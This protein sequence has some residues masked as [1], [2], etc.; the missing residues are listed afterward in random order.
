MDTPVCI[1]R[2]KW[3][4]IPKNPLLAA[5]LLL[6]QCANGQLVIEDFEAGNLSN[7]T[8]VDL[9]NDSN[10]VSIVNSTDANTS[11]VV[12]V[13]AETNSGN[14]PGAWLQANTNTIDATQNN[15][16]VTFDFQMVGGSNFDDAMFLIGDLDN[17]DYI[18]YT[19]NEH[20]GSNNLHSYINTTKS[21]I[22]TDI[23]AGLTDDTWYSATLTWNYQSNT[24]NYTINNFNSGSTIGS[25]STSH[26]LNNVQFAWGSLND[27]AR[28]D[29]ITITVTKPLVGTDFSDAST[30]LAT[31]GAY[32]NTQLD[33]LDTSDGITVSN[34]INFND[35]QWEGRS[36]IFPGFSDP[37]VII[38]R[39]DGNQNNTL[40]SIGDTISTSTQNGVYFEITIDSTTSIDLT[41]IEFE[42]RQATTNNTRTLTFGT[43]LTDTII[44]KEVGL[45][46]NEVDKQ[47]IEFTGPTYTGLTNTTVGFYFFAGEGSGTRDL[48]FDNIIL[49]GSVALTANNDNVTTNIQGAIKANVLANDTGYDTTTLQIINSPNNGTA[50][51]QDGSIIYKHTG[52]TAGTDT[53]RYSIDNAGSSTTQ[54]AELTI[55]ITNDFRL[56]PTTLNIPI[57]PPASSPDEL[58]YVDALP[59]LSFPGCVAIVQIPGQPKA[60]FIAS[61]NGSVWYV[62]DTTATT[63][64]SH[65]VLD[66]TK[67]TNFTNGRS[68]YSMTCYPDFAT[69]GNIIINYQ[70]DASRLPTPGTGETVHD[71]MPGLDQN[72]S[73]DDTI[74]CDLRVSRFTLSASHLA[75]VVANGMSDAENDAILAT[76]YPFI[77]LAEQA[78]FHSINDCHFG[79][80]GYLYVSFGDEGGQ[81][82]VYHNTQQLTKD[83]YSSIIRID[84]DPTSTNPKPTAH[85]SIA[86]GPIDANGRHGFFTD[87]TNQEPNFRIPADNPFIHTSLGGTWDGDLNGNDL[88]G[89]LDAIRTEIWA[90][91]F[92]NPFKFHLEQNPTT[93]TTEA[94]VGDVGHGSREEFTIIEAGDNAGWAYYEGDIVT[95][96][97]SHAD[98]PGGSTPH[99]LPLYTYSHAI[100][101]SAI[102]GIIYNNTQLSQLT[103][104]YVCGDY[105]DGH[106]WSITRDGTVN[107]LDISGNGIVD[108]ELDA[109]TG[110][111]FVLEINTST[112]KR[113]T[114]ESGEADINY[115]KTLTET[116]IFADLTDLSPNPG[117]IPY[118]PNLTFWSDNALKQRWMAIPGLS[119]TITFASEGKW[120]FPTGQIWVKHFEY[121]LDQTNPGTQI[122]RLETRVLV[123]NGASSYGVSYRWNETGTEAYLVDQ[124]GDDLTIH[125]T[126]ANGQLQALDWHIPSRTECLTCHT[127]QAGVG[128][129][130]NTRQLNRQG[131]IHN[132]TDNFLTLLADGGYLDGF[133]GEPSDYPKHEQPDD[134]SVNIEH[135]VRAYLDV[136]CAYCHQ[137]GGTAT[138]QWDGRAHISLEQTGLLYGTSVSES[139]P[140][141][142]DHLIRPGQLDQ[143]VVWNR[144]NARTAI[145]DT[146][147]GYTQ[148][149]PL[150]SNLLDQDAINMMRE[151]IL[152]YANVSPT[153]ADTSLSTSSISE[154][155]TL[156]TSLGSANNTDP[157]IRNTTSDQSQ[158]SYQIIA[159]NE[160]H[161]FSI[162]ATTG[163]IQVNGLLDFETTQQHTLTIEVSD[164]FTPNPGIDTRTVI[165]QLIDETTNDDTEDIDG[166]G[167]FDQWEASHG[168]NAVAPGSDTDHDGTDTFFEFISDGNPNAHDKSLQFQLDSPQDDTE[169]PKLTWNVRN[170]IQLNTHYSLQ[171]TTDLSSNWQTLNEN[172]DYQIISNQ[173][174]GNGISKITIQTNNT[175]PTEFFRL[176]KLP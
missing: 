58:T 38:A 175:Q 150:S 88:S 103:G 4:Q 36:D 146:Y 124:T 71:V 134:T 115:P 21:A 34:W 9:N 33:D 47:T 79:P 31:G 68:I 167:I 67:V 18:G 117:V 141:I 99:K 12:E 112:V 160:N 164:N 78:I 25:G 108:F 8:F 158:L 138:T 43:S 165:I 139:A 59:G 53:L 48:E 161:Q 144:I 52:T 125:Y 84:V 70:G 51:I 44:F 13:A 132:T 69:T 159:G 41:S 73:P 15:F 129:S 154:N 169:Q 130:M 170:G 87:P 61:I 14:F 80:D 122:Q 104:S 153:P 19:F 96:T 174:L 137:D 46:R 86:V 113:I 98:M 100:G 93:G 30:F 123:E 55:N 82:S 29:N 64:T 42:W 50:S 126:D 3:T 94:W 63:P 23:L 11:S 111:I 57:D 17:D 91:G 107:R 76:E 89:Q 131:T 128:L 102:G 28:F 37:E 1:P 149:P 127:Q 119:D 60:V 109:A 16:I 54:E 72:G 114:L 90:L 75:D 32:D 35:G 172:L 97:V 118:S 26:S 22:A 27:T 85:Y 142:T 65:Q 83:Q 74:T 133:T 20:D 143:S 157:D 7:F 101:N 120:T 162:N 105:T 24:L 163:E 145:N 135:R 5:T 77:N 106:I 151:W 166:N 81:N 121:D 39:L 148:M 66:L 116:G 62:P 95:P 147:N 152:N 49:N 140:N 171:K 6:I 110:D 168:L 176:Q 92:R 56:D 173:D 155:T 45:N 136:N 10:S 40:Q 156:N 2:A